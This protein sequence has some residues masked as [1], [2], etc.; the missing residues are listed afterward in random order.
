M[1]MIAASSS[2]TEKKSFKEEHQKALNTTAI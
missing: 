1:L 2:I